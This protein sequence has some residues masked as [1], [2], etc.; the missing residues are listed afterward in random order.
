MYSLRNLLSITALFL[1]ASCNSQTGKTGGWSGKLVFTHSGDIG[2]YEFAGK[3]QKS[4]LKQGT[5]PTVTRNGEIYFINDAFPKRQSLVRKTNAAFTQFKNVLD[6]SNDNPLYKQQLEDYS[7][8]RG[9]G[10]SGVLDRMADP[11]VSPDGKYLS[12]T[13]FGYPGQA[14]TNNC[15][16]VFDLASAQLIT[17]FDDKYYGN[18]MADGRLL[19][20]GSH[21]TVSVDGNIYNSKTPGI[22]IS[23]AAL[24]AVTRVDQDLDDPAPY[25][26]TP[27]PDGKKIAFI[28]N[29]HVWV[30][31]N[32]GANMKQLTDTDNDNIETFP[33]WSP[34]G[35]NI[36]CWSYKTFERSYYTAVAI[37]SANAVKPV[38]LADKAAVWPRDSKNYRISGGS[39]Q[40]QWIK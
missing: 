17:K 14:F 12:V 20:S 27:S 10:I 1:F 5:Q 7:V 40:L 30:M 23:D 33:A 3:K 25:H 24:K 16:A 32:N 22:F 29:N 18:W 8:I 37:V 9:T 36:A 21:K 19:M 4:I 6:M 31:D 15:V 13:I 34:D 28:L 11:R 35:K 39:L 2:T 26:A 38:V